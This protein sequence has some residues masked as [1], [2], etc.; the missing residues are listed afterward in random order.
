MKIAVA[1]V[2]VVVVSPLPVIAGNGQFDILGI[3]IG[4]GNVEVQSALL[5]AGVSSPSTEKLPCATETSVSRRN[6]KCVS[7]IHGS[8]DDVSSITVE[9]TEDYP[10]RPGVSV[11]S[12]IVA[13]YKYDES[14]GPRRPTFLEYRDKLVDRYGGPTDMNESYGQ[15]IWGE[16]WCRKRRDCPSQKEHLEFNFSQQSGFADTL[17]LENPN[18]T[19]SQ[20]QS[21]RDAVEK[22]REV[23]NPKF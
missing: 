19:G 23:G 10:T 7:S 17:E 6:G 14:K 3:K 4:D 21:K 12:K 1:F 8:I 20:E 18:L 13:R 22:A 11:A 16:V 5:K 15:L 2:L 9:F